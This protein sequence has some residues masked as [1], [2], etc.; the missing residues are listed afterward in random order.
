MQHLA[1]HVKCCTF[2]IFYSSCSPPLLEMW[3][4]YSCCLQ[5]EIEP[6]VPHRGD[7]LCLE[8]IWLSSLWWPYRASSYCLR[9]LCHVVLASAV[10][11]DWKLISILTSWPTWI[12]SIT[13][14][15]IPFFH[16][17]NWPM[18]VPAPPC[19]NPSSFESTLLT[20]EHWVLTLV[21]AEHCIDCSVQRCNHGGNFAGNES[22]LMGWHR[23]EGATLLRDLEKVN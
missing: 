2:P 8:R 20:D 7:V 23:L 6:E 12:L 16:V 13:L 9:P 4:Y 14:F 10:S 19:V 15:F 11:V 3:R 21:P 22:H 18:L 17:V 1:Q 5:R